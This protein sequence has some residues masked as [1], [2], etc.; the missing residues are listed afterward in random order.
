MLTGDYRETAI[1]VAHEAGIINKDDETAIEGSVLSAE[2]FRSR[3]ENLVNETT[4]EGRRV[5]SFNSHDA[6]KQFQSD[7]VE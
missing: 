5:W 3:C 1:F 2:E 7:I 6:L 4:N